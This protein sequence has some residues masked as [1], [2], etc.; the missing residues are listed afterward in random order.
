MPADFDAITK[1]EI[2]DANCHIRPSPLL[3]TSLGDDE[4]NGECRPPALRAK[5]R[6]GILECQRSVLGRPNDF[7][8]FLQYRLVAHVI[9]PFRD[10]LRVRAF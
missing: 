1:V 10:G 5:R 2:N 9:R 8:A 4:G 6:R 7:T 3:V